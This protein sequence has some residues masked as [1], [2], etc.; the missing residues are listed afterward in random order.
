[1]W[2]LQLVRRNFTAIITDIRRPDGEAQ[3]GEEM[4]LSEEKWKTKCTK[5]RYKQES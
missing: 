5:E 2:T 3:L 1:M 4:K